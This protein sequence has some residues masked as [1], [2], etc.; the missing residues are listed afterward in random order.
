MTPSEWLALANAILVLALT[1]IT[2]WYAWSTAQMLRQ[3]KVQ[4]EATQRQAVTAERTLQHLL[5]VAE[6]Q[7]G[8]ART[9]VQ[10]T[11]EAALTHV[12][13]W[14]GQNLVNLANLYAIPEV[15]LVP[16]SGV[17][18]I[19]HARAVAP[20]AAAPLSR[21]LALLERCESEFEVL[22]VLGRRSMADARQQTDRIQA[23]FAEADEQLRLAQQAIQ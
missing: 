21:A 20:A 18:A 23:I 4:S 9:V 5:Q 19:E 7:R 3:L 6:E 14:R 2:G 15:V 16:E 13:H 22:G 1:G 8:V 11:I 10:T 12:E 17:R